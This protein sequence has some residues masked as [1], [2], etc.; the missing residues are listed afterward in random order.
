[1]I[2]T[3]ISVYKN[4]TNRKRVSYLKVLYN[5]MFN[6]SYSVMVWASYLQKVNLMFIKRLI[7]NHLEVKY[8]ILISMNAKIGENLKFDHF[9]GIVI[10]EGVVIGD[11]CKIYQQVT[12][13]QKGGEYPVVGDNVVIYAGAKVIGGVKIGNNALIGANA[14]VLH[15]VPDNSIAV[16]VPAI[17]KAKNN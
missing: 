1:M 3:M 8:S 5:W 14:V 2:S 11:N 6:P 15:D 10:G 9:M 4:M 7:Q 12:L 16:G 17:I 13:G